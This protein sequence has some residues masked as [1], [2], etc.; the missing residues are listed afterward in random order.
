M[1][2]SGLSLPALQRAPRRDRRRLAAL[3]TLA[4]V[5]GL[6]AWLDDLPATHAPVLP[7]AGSESAATSS[8]PAPRADP[9]KAP[10]A[11]AAQARQAE[12]K[13]RFD[14]AVVMLHARQYE[15]AVTALHRVLALAPDLP[16]AHVNMGFAL[17]GLQRTRA[18]RDFFDGAT[19]LKP[20]QANAYYG[21]ALA[22][23]ADG[24]LRMA[25]GAM[26][27][28]LHLA[29]SESDAHLRRARAALWEWETRLQ[30]AAPAS[31]SSSTPPPAA[32]TR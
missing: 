13:R 20:D 25:M 26:R 27:S 15:H 28:Y 11:H 12:V 7:A 21:L 17:L 6:G 23:E 31:T 19:A 32:P 10:A 8:P 18:A 3:G 24:D 16:E 2:G 29:R 30:E 22:W 1:R 4:L 9:K 14:E 5:L